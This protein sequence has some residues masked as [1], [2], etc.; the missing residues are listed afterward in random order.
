MQLDLLM[1]YNVW[2]QCW[3]F[4]VSFFTFCARIW[5]FTSMDSFMWMFMLGLAE[6]FSTMGATEGLFS[7]MSSLM[8]LQES[9][10]VWENVFLHSLHSN[11]V[12]H[13]CV[14]L[15][16]DVSE[17]LAWRKTWDNSCKE[18]F[19]FHLNAIRGV[20]LVFPIE[21]IWIDISCTKITFLS[22]EREDVVGVMMHG[23][24]TFHKQ[25]TRM[26]WFVHVFF[27]GIL[28]EPS[29]QICPHM[30]N[31]QRVFYRCAGSYDF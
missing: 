28:V 20:A 15:H 10:L 26:I 16:C 31:N 19:A 3:R 8:Y 25:C 17:Y 5:L 6:T 18:K 4:M 11:G 27:G 21:T 9:S 29:R 30:K 13:L 14:S 24:R 22:C 12:F 7:C 23:Q 1:S 2:P